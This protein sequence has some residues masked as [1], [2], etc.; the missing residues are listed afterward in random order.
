[1]I[2]ALVVGGVLLFGGGIATGVSLNKQK[3][4]KIIEEQTQMIGAIQDGQRDLLE[5]ASKPVVLDAELRS[6][7][8]QVPVQCIEA[9]G[10]DALSVHCAWATCAAFGQSSA[11]R[12][13]CSKLTELLVR[14]LGFT[15]EEVQYR[16]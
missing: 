13:E 3:T 11:N 15:A 2:A 14:T 1:M 12:P 4:H 6:N 8:A 5:A 16:D 9:A 10:G 7:L